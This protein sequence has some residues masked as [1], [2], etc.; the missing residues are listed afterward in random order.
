MQQKLQYT[1]ITDHNLLLV[2]IRLTD[3]S[4]ACQVLSQD[5][6]VIVAQN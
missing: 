4:V 3:W 5:D 6:I 1:N 2:E